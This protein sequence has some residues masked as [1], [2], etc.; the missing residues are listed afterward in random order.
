MKYF[1]IHIFNSNSEATSDS[2]ICSF[3]S[4]RKEI[5]PGRNCRAAAR[6][7]SG[8]GLE[9]GLFISSKY[10]VY[11]YSQ[12]LFVFSFQVHSNKHLF[13]KLSFLKAVSL[14]N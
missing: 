4:Q 3:F 8:T 6:K 10:S 12:Y 7:R 13:H 5:H 14:K 9:F 1:H 2:L 11:K